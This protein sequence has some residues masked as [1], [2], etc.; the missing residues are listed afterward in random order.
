MNKPHHARVWAVNK[1][2]KMKKIIRCLAVAFVLMS[3]VVSISRV[4]AKSILV[5]SVTCEVEDV[6]L[7]D[8]SKG[9][10]CYCV[11]DQNNLMFQVFALPKGEGVEYCYDNH[12]L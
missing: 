2:E 12:N 11:V 3:G 9:Q 4:S 6:D 1:E 7:K 8:P 5:R 10:Q